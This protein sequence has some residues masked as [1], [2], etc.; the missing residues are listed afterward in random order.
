ME[1][2]N[3]KKTYLMLPK[4]LR[5]TVAGVA[6]KYGLEFQ[7]NNENEEITIWGERSQM[8]EAMRQLKKEYGIID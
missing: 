8:E 1:E 2:K 5:R 6:I 4:N 3:M 7:S